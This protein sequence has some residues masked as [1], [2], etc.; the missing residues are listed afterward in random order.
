MDMNRDTDA[1]KPARRFGISA[2][3]TGA[4][5]ASTLLVAIASVAM[6]LLLRHQERQVRLLANEH[7]RALLATARIER[8]TTLLVSQLGGLAV[9]TS[10]AKR[11]ASEKLLRDYISLFDSAVEDLHSLQIPEDV[12]AQLLRARDTFESTATRLGVLVG[13]RLELQQEMDESFNRLL[14]L[15]AQTSD[16]RQLTSELLTE[17]SRVFNQRNAAAFRGRMQFLLSKLDALLK[18]GADEAVLNAFARDCRRLLDMRDK[19]FDYRNAISAAMMQGRGQASALRGLTSE[20]AHYQATVLEKTAARNLKY[21]WQAKIMTMSAAVVMLAFTCLIVLYIRRGVTLRLNRMALRVREIGDRDVVSKPLDLPEH[22]NDELGALARVLNQYALALSSS[23]EKFRAMVESSSDWLWEVDAQS[24]YTYASPRVKDILGYEPEE[25]L[26]RT[27]FD[28]MAPSS[29]ERVAKEFKTIVEKKAPFSQLENPNQHKSGR[30]VHLETAGVP[31]LGAQGKLM[32]YR[33]VDRDISSRIRSEQEL[34]KLKRSVDHNPLS[35]VITDTRGIVEYV[36][37]AF[38]SITGYTP[39]EILGQ[40]M[41]VLKSGMHEDA[42]YQD[43]KETVLAGRVWSNEICNLTKDGRLIWEQVSIAPVRDQDCEIS[44]YVFIQQ[45]ISDKKE[46]EKL[47]EDVERIMRHDL[48]NPLGA[49]LSL[50]KILLEEDNLTPEQREIIMVIHKAGQTMLNMVDLSLDMF[51]METGAYT[52]SPEPTDVLGIIE[53]VIEQSRSTLYGKDLVVQLTMDGGPVPQGRTFTVW[54]EE[55]LLFT[56]LSNLFINALEASPLNQT[57]SIELNDKEPQGIE[58]S[59]RNRGVVPLSIRD[60]FFDKYQTYGKASGTG[61]GT[62]SAKLLASTMGYDMRLEISD[63]DDS[64][65]IT[66]SIPRRI[67]TSL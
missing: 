56:I 3:V 31:I 63:E 12:V 10:D 17:T 59:I 30:V 60:K 21:I 20:M 9:S 28:I 50:P 41:D 8:E 65:R 7:A 2:K 62:Y 51:K 32:G 22:P 24:R 4:L 19:D 58:L 39:E 43:I 14:N 25:L 40:T 54:S 27:P 61:L 1:F 49:I 57:I 36:N 15:E 64:T 11:R 42:F 45:D 5:I 13:Q 46:L 16:G 34:R 55:R 33:G 66:I 18:Y 23:E 53:R 47:K 26:G 37:P 52:Y 38:S 67:S 48:K 35:V 6:V 44:N 29:R